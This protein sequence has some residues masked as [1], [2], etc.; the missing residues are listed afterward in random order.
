MHASSRAEQGKQCAARTHVDMLTKPSN[1]LA[2]EFSVIGLCSKIESD[3]I[4]GSGRKWGNKS[5][6]IVTMMCHR[7][8]ASVYS[9]S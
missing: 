2:L 5:V 7:V 1:G 6:D 8:V 4:S 9:G 3:R